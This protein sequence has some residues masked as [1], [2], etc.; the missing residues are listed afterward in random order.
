M[1]PLWAGAGSVIVLAALVVAGVAWR[2][3]RE[4]DRL[5]TQ[6]MALRAIRADV[7]TLAERRVD[8]VGTRWTSVGHEPR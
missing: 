6:V 5:T 3:A 4:V 2:I 8:R 7:G 1:S